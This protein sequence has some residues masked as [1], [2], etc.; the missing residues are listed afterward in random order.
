MS[1]WLILALQGDTRARRKGKTGS[2]GSSR[3]IKQARRVG[4]KLI[5]YE[6]KIEWNSERKSFLYMC[7]TTML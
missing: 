5:E 3:N 2:R 7:A 4:E 6:I 1:M